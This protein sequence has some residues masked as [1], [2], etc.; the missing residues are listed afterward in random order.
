MSTQLKYNE[1][2][3]DTCLLEIVDANTN[4]TKIFRFPKHAFENS[5]SGRFTYVGPEY[6]TPADT[7]AGKCGVKQAP[8]SVFSDSS[9][10]KLPIIDSL[11]NLQCT[12]RN[13]AI[14]LLLAWF[15]STVKSFFTKPI[16]KRWEV[17]VFAFYSVFS[18]AWY[19]ILP[20]LFSSPLTSTVSTQIL[21]S[22][23]L[24]VAALLLLM[25]NKRI[26]GLLAFR[27]K[28][29]L[30]RGMSGDNVEK[31]LVYMK[32]A[33]LVLVIV[34]IGQSTALLVINIDILLLHVRTIYE[35]KLL[36]DIFSAIFSF[37]YVL[38]PAVVTFILYKP[39]H[40]S[41]EPSSS[42]AKLNG[43]QSCMSNVTNPNYST[44]SRAY[45][46]ATS[47][48]TDEIDIQIGSQPTTKAD[49][50]EKGKA[51]APNN[52][53]DPKQTTAEDV[54][55]GTEIGAVET[56]SPESPSNTAPAPKEKKINKLVS[57]VQLQ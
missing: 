30:R 45:A 8:S 51:A 14:F 10:Q 42:V 25:T 7:N 9:K 26:G 19:F 27:K 44:S 36:T 33:N 54:E 13:S 22:A 55:P 48:R 16:L 23:E 15:N 17:R 28:S 49:T 1:G 32:Q 53:V 2:F 6:N 3:V 24:Y 4:T 37:F 41:L 50:K 34:I 40:V 35:S 11:W 18:L 21:W 38:E 5:E 29:V 56:A 12:L 47:C 20:R 31:A 43:E 52:V 57:M 39:S 46:E